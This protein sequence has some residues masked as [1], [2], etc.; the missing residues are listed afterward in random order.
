[1]SN[2]L[3]ARV[4]LQG[5]IHAARGNMIDNMMEERGR[6]FASDREAWATLKCQLEV[7]EAMLKSLGKIHK[8]MW[9]AVKENNPDA[10]SAL[11]S[12]MERAAGILA[13]EMV[14]CSVEAKISVEYTEE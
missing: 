2:S 13:E 6:G 3:S 7:A 10:F 11:A 5:D 4:R 14:I 1:M 9:D 12:E 8:E